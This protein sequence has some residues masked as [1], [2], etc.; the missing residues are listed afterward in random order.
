MT[1]LIK[2]VHDIKAALA[3]CE[4]PIGLV[5]TMGALHA[6]HISLIEASKKDCK[7]TVVYIFVNP[8]QFGPNEDFKKYPRDLE[9][10]LKI[11][12]EHEV[13]FVFAPEEEEVYPKNEAKKIIIPPDYLASILCGKTRENHFSGVATVVK[14][15]LDIIQ[16]DY[17]YFG[18]KDLQQLYVIRWLVNEYNIHTFVRACSIIR[19]SSGLAYSSRNNYLS[20]ELRKLAVNLYKS[21]KFAKQNIRSGMFTVSKATLESLVFLSQFPEIKV[22]YFEARDKENLAKVNEQKTNDLYYLVAAHIGGVRLI[23]NIEI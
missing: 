22:E 2:T 12:T 13:H 7:T 14:R 21:L 10:D 15:F 5:P 9:S 16:P 18:E 8:L 17:V 23:D 4:R 19:E 20:D 3:K 6:G 1:M 11:C